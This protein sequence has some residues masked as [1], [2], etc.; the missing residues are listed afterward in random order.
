[1][2]NYND[3]LVDEYN[4]QCGITH[5]VSTKEM[6]VG[7]DAIDK[8][9]QLIE[10]LD[11]PKDSFAVFDENTFEVAGQKVLQ[12]LRKMGGETRHYV[13][14]NENIHHPDEKS[15][16][17]L[18]MAMEPMPKLIIAV[19]SGTINDLSRF[20]ATR[21]K[22]PY[23]VIA[24]APSM[25]GYAS[26]VIPLTRG[27]MKISYIGIAPE[28]VISDLDILKNAP[29]KLTAAGF[30]DIM[31][32]VPAN[33]DWRFGSDMFGED[34]CPCI[35][36]LMNFAVTK[37]LDSAAGLNT[38]NDD[39]YKELT[40]A[41]ALSGIAMQM[42]GNSRP[43][44]GAEHHMSHFLE[45]RDGSYNRPNA[46][47]GAKVG[48]TTLISMRLYEKLFSA[49]P[50]E[51]MDVPDEAETRQKAEVAFGKVG[52]TVMSQ[53]DKIFLDKA[54]WAECKKKI[55]D[56]WDEYKEVVSGF[57]KMRGEFEDI[58]KG[59]SGP[60]KPQDLGY[61]K[62]D[63]YNAILYARM[64]RD[65]VTIL[66]VLDNWGLLEQYALEVVQEIFE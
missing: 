57:A 50:P 24:T 15:I 43:A 41:L 10:K 12:T 58:L 38:G 60:V 45:M 26:N 9:P 64:V 51:Q 33:L 19:G 49:Q 35:E 61:S 55:I 40:E 52:K 13:F 30:G 42:Q 31:G 18:M 14:E 29:E 3:Y 11:L 59:S 62:D 54:E 8:I 2:I 28:I 27:G 39:S 66:E 37:C 63:I 22:I 4:C 16:G 25:D 47:H 56:K 7:T 17:E 46:Y 34:K 6:I 21:L 20:C 65:R 1:M 5:S 36:N 48:V 53:K 32:K 23:F 44:S